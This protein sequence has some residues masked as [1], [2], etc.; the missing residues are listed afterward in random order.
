MGSAPEGIFPD[1]RRCADLRS[2]S[3]SCRRFSPEA[4]FGSCTTR[5]KEVLDND[6]FGKESIRKNTGT[7]E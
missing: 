5:N 2:P 6:T 1:L 4:R 3:F 7:A